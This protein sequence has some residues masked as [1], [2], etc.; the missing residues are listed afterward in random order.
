MKS[1][2]E[3]AGKYN[4]ERLTVIGRGKSLSLLCKQHIPAGP[5]IAI[6][7]AILAVDKLDMPNDVYS[8]QK[9][10]LFTLSTDA[11]LLVHTPESA[12][13][14][15]IPN[16][17]EW[18]NTDYKLEVKA[19]SV[20]SCVAIAKLWGCKEV[21][22]LCCDAAVNQCTEAHGDPATKPQDYLMHRAIVE[23]VAKRKHIK[24]TWK[25]PE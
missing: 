13:G 1:I 17:Y 19:P 6:N 7:Q 25:I 20:A 18:R 11:P 23:N 8:M 3:L 15:D 4:G 14:L 5:V 21:L 16:A 10:K 2:N 9:D 24:V 22:F 12:K